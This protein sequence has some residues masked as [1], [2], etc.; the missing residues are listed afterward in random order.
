MFPPTGASVH[1]NEVG[2]PMGWDA[3]GEPDYDPDHYVPDYG[4]VDMDDDEP[5][6]T[7]WCNCSD[8]NCQAPH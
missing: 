8:S 3:G 7:E 1:Y 5:D 2:E 6:D 4:D